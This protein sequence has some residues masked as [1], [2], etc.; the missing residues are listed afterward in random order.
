VGVQRHVPGVDLD[1]LYLLALL[2]QAEDTAIVNGDR[3]HVLEHTS[4]SLQEKAFILVW[5]G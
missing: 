4:H 2:L 1:V 3:A 5:L